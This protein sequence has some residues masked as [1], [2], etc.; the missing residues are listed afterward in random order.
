[1]RG[2][3]EAHLPADQLSVLRIAEANER[4]LIEGFVRGISETLDALAALQDD[5]E[6]EILAPDPDPG[7]NRL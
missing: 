2:V 5:P 3:I 7:G 6:A 1:M 4:E